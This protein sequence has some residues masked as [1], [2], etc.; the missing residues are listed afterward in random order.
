MVFFASHRVRPVSL[1]CGIATPTLY[2]SNVLQ[3]GIYV[4]Q[5]R[6]YLTLWVGALRHSQRCDHSNRQLQK[7]STSDV[8]MPTRSECPMTA[9]GVISKTVPQPSGSHLL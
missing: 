1:L 4:L 8:R 5:S 6:D 9:Y 3:S 7:E 2:G